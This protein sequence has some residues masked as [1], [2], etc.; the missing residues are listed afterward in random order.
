M[1]KTAVIFSP[2]FY[3]HNPGKTHPE[4]AKRLKAI[5]NELCNGVLSRSKKWQFVNPEKATIENVELVHDINYI[6][7]I[8]TV[9][10]SGGG[11][12]DSGDTV[13][14]LKSFDVALYAIGGT[15]KAVNL[16]MKKEYEKRLRF[17][18][19]ARASR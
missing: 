3:Q 19:P 7:F 13:A 15:I 17:S 8:D 4:S 1:P 10:K 11:V 12:L 2:K 16:V 5:V 18:T 6:N 9:C 14:S